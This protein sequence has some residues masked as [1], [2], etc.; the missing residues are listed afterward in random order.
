MP[1]KGKLSIKSSYRPTPNL[2]G[3]YRRL[4]RARE[5]LADLKAILDAIDERWKSSDEHMTIEINFDTGEYRP[6]LPKGFTGITLTLKCFIVTGELIYNLRAALDY[7]V[8][9]LAFLD[10]GRPRGRTQFPIEKCKENSERRRNGY[11]KGVNDIH[12]AHIETLQPYSGCDW[13][14]ILRKLSNADKHRELTIVA[15]QISGHVV[16]TLGQVGSFADRTHGFIRR[17]KQADGSEVD[18]HVDYSFQRAVTFLDG[19]PV[20]DTLEQLTAGVSETLDFFKPDFPV[21]THDPPPP[22]A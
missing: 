16:K 15:H 5:H 4:D 13:T 2:G 21:A 6:T 22:G 7:L 12:R 20:I 8:Y 17:A 1:R 10:S 14:E 3:A 11:L 18:M 19:A 9:Q